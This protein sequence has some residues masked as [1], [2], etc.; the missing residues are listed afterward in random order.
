M[1]AINNT[2]FK[3][4]CLMGGVAVGAGAIAGG[5]FL[6]SVATGAL[7]GV[8]RH[9]VDL[10]AMSLGLYDRKASDISTIVSFV[11][12]IFKGLAVYAVLAARGLALAI[13]PVTIFGFVLL[14]YG[15]QI[16]AL[17]IIKANPEAVN[18]CIS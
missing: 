9:V 13:T 4:H 6:S 18:R 7:C 11:V 10:T 14:S 12:G 2:G 15:L 1:T 17:E 3:A 5:I 16:M 8:V